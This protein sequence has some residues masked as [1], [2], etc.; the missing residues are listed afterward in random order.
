MLYDSGTMTTAAPSEKGYAV[1]FETSSAHGSIAL[2]R[3]GDI[4]EVRM[5]SGPRKHAVEFLPTIDE[6]CKAH[7]IVPAMIRNVYVSGGPGSFTGLRIGMTAARMI[8][9]ANGASVAA[10]PTLEVIAQNASAAPSPPDSVAVI[11]DA[12]RQHVYAATFIRRDDHYETMA[13]AAEFEPA[14]F[15]G[16]QDRSCAVLG[17]GVLYHR[18]AVEA[19]GLAILP[20]SLY[21]PRAE[22]VFR[23]GLARARD[24]RLDDRRKLIPVYVRPPEAE[25]NW[26]QRQQLRSVPTE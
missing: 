4:V 17:E 8:A 2:G 5:F 11:L 23:L 16:R 7:G 14:Q 22:T 12:K 24:G 6:L 3:D 20:E 21:P 1:A 18:E 13:E 10:V 9:L 15:L 19:C 26:E 25:E